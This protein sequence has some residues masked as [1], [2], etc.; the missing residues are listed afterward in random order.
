M[1]CD[2]LPLSLD[3][4]APGHVKFLAH[5]SLYTG[6]G[7]APLTHVDPD[8]RQDTSYTKSLDRTFAS[9][10]RADKFLQSPNLEAIAGVWARWKRSWNQDLDRA[11]AETQQQIGPQGHP[12]PL[13][14]EIID[15]T[16]AES[17]NLWLAFA[18]QFGPRAPVAAP[19]VRAFSVA[20]RAEE[21]YSKIVS[22]LEAAEGKG[23]NPLPA[24]FQREGMVAVARVEIAGKTRIYVG[25]KVPKGSLGAI[26]RTEAFPA[27]EI[28]EW[29]QKNVLN[30]GEELGGVS[31]STTHAEGPIQDAI[32]RDAKAAGVDPKSVEGTIG[33]ATDVCHG[34][35]GNLGRGLP[36]VKPENPAK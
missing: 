1:S 8:G 27:K 11:R 4:A 20:A 33:A 35:Q 19:V 30:E 9:P 15:A 28:G 34:C 5:T 17:A 26:E 29:V 3:P 31:A 14:N 23:S 7:N 22:A 18:H 16:P 24:V 13:T 6:M 32:I 21:I 10:E 2:P 25:V 36:N 12:T